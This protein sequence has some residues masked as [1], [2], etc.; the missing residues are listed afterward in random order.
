MKGNWDQFQN[1]CSIRLHQ[2]AIA[3]S[4]A[5][6]SLF[7]SILKETIPKTL[8]VPNHGFL[9]FVKMQLGPSNPTTCSLMCIVG[10]D[11]D[12]AQLIILI[13]LKHFAGS[14]HP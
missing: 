9:I 10:S 1:L 14:F 2:S 12:V 5:P 6:I 4:D 3:D 7:T 8:A 13:D 11:L